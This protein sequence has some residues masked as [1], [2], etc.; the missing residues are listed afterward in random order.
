MTIFRRL[1][2]GDFHCK[3]TPHTEISKLAKK[4]AGAKFQKVTAQEIV[5]LCKKKPFVWD[6][7]YYKPTQQLLFDLREIYMKHKPPYKA[8]SEDCNTIAFEFKYYCLLLKRELGL[9][10]NFAVGQVAGDF[11]WMKNHNVNVVVTD[12]GIVYF[13]A[14]N[15]AIYGL[16]VTDEIYI[17]FFI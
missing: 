17:M 11:Y 14:S 2:E 12:G 4:Y 6:T 7:E 10:F 9:D 16:S 13:S 5:S 8:N 15:N 1:L 3:K